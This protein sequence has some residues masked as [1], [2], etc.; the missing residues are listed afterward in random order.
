[1]CSLIC[2]TPH[3]NRSCSSNYRSAL[4]E[5]AHGVEWH[6][7]SCEFWFG[8]S[9][10]HWNG[11]SFFFFFS[12]NRMRLIQFHL[13]SRRATN[14]DD[15]EELTGLSRYGFL[16]SVSSTGRCIHK[17]TFSYLSN[18]GICD[19]VASSRPFVDTKY[20]MEGWQRQPGS[21]QGTQRFGH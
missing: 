16:K 20:Y 5:N 12:E 13:H 10:Q 21:C 6:W 18:V 8:L 7:Q 1:M 3:P 11:I 2:S 17:S 9:Y 14:H 19:F 15:Q 4:M